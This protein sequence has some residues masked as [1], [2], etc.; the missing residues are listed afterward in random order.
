MPTD[1]IDS[2]AIPSE[3][4]VADI[5]AVFALTGDLD[6]SDIGGGWTTNLPITGADRPVVAR[7]H[8]GGK[9]TDRLLAEQAARIALADAGVPAVRPLA[10]PSGLTVVRLPDGR[11]AEPEPFVSWDARM[12]TERLIR[13][14]FGVMARM[15]DVLRTAELP[16]AARTAARANQVLAADAAA[17]TRLGAVRMRSWGD[18]VLSRFADDVVAHVDDVSAAEEPLVAGQVSQVVH[19]DFWDNVLF[20][21][22]DLAALIDF[23]FMADRPRIDDLALTAYLWFLQPGKGIPDATGMRELRRFV[24]AYDAAADLPLAL[25]ERLVLPLAIARPTSLVGR[26]Q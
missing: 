12:N 8:Q 19:G 2:R 7:I 26:T 25:D 16:A 17:A 5:A 21:G 1:D 14:G 18:P 10:G 20:R 6:W 24:D 23:D 3:A 9:S 15:H 22:D 13:Q 4:L 11:L